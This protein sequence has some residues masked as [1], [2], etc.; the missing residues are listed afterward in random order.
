M[1]V[2]TC[3]CIFLFVLIGFYYKR[4]GFQKLFENGFEILEKEK[5]ME[6]FS[7]LR[8]RPEGLLLPFPAFGPLLKLLARSTSTR[9]PSKPS[10]PSL[11]REPRNGPAQS[12][13]ATGRLAFPISG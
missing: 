4:K 11:A 7:L 8:F 9:Q 13:E 12:A 2:H 5:K 10:C 1:L 6:I 3:R